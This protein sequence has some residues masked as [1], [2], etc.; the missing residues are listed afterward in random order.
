MIYIHFRMNKKSNLKR[1]GAANKEA[2][3]KFGKKP[4][5]LSNAELDAYFKTY[6][7]GFGDHHWQLFREVDKIVKVEK[8]LYPGCHCHIT[9]SLVFKNV[10]YVDNYKKIAGCFAEFWNG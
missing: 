10:V 6:K 4:K 7:N 2:N 8:V 3:P 1:K 5:K 9:A